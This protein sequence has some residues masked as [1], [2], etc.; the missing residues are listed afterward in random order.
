MYPAALGG[1]SGKTTLHPRSRPS[2]QDA[3]SVAMKSAATKSL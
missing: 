2:W 1:G 3:L